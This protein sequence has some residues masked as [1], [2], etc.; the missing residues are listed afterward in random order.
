M[1]KLD[2]SLIKL[3]KFRFSVADH[4]KLVPQMVD[5]LINSELIARFC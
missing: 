2:K 1:I 5:K 4:T 3:I